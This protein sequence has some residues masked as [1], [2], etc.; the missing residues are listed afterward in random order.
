V[1]QLQDASIEQQ[2]LTRLDSSSIQQLTQRITSSSSPSTCNGQKR[3]SDGNGC[4]GVAGQMASLQ[5]AQQQDGAAASGQHQLQD[6]AATLQQ[7]QQQQQQVQ[8][9]VQHPLVP[10][11]AVTAEACGEHEDSGMQLVGARH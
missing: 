7:Q 3:N 5:L 8:V 1:E 2:H 6:K 10:V 4:S 11:V 9:Q